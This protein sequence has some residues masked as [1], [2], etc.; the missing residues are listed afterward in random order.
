M[1]KL[2]LQDKVASGLLI[3]M[4]V[5]NPLTGQFVMQAVVWAFDTMLLYGAYISI[6]TTVYIMGL[7]MFY[8][9]KSEQ[10]NVPSKKSKAKPQAYL[11]Q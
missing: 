10:T 5:T 2:K 4:L 6:V 9:A 8:Y 3:A 7:G 11:T 1:T